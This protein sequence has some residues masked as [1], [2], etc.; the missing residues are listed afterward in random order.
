[1]RENGCRQGLTGMGYEEIKLLKQSGKSTVSLVKEEGGERYFIRKT[2]QG[3]HLVYQ[4]LRELAH[5]YL[6]AVYEVSFDKDKTTVVEE[7]IEG[8][9]VGSVKLSEKQ[10]LTIVGELCDV[11][12]FLHEKGIVHRDI[13]PSNILIAEDGHIRL[14]DFDA[15]RMPKENADQDTVPLGTK[16]YAPPEQYGFSQ[17]DERADIYA[18]GVTVKQLLGGN[19][20]KQ[21]YK[22]IFSKCTNLDPEKRYQSVRQIKK[23]FSYMWDWRA[24]I[25]CAAAAVLAAVI[26]G[27]A[28][29]D[30]V[31][32]DVSSDGETDLIVLPAPENPHW[33]GETGIGL[34][35]HVPESGVGR[36]QRYG[37]RLYRSDNKTPPDLEKDK[38]E[39]EGE[40]SGNNLTTDFFDLN[41][42]EEFWDNGFYYFSVCASGDGITYADSSYVLSDAFAFT[43][44]DAPRLPAPEGLYWT[45]KQIGE[46]RY[47]FAA[48]SN[49]EDYADQDSFNAIVYGEDREYVTNNISVKQ[50]IFEK[51]WPGVRIRPEFVNVPGKSYRFAVQVLSSRPNEYR[52]SLPVEPCP[53]EAYL[54]QPLKIPNL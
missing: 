21:R 48:I 2:L 49:W 1:M 7:Y 50:F 31:Q 10:C 17:T 47:Y 44:K 42:A 46:D 37:W 32:Q 41:F 40:M 39:R 11:L 28:L 45:M 15:A 29:S 12:I 38:W 27:K 14:I 5:S 53:G 54:S 30:S 22:R 52:S 34:W 25:L 35:G 24:G 43:G 36:D 9:T 6:P 3:Q 51:G 4:N 18:F 16:G 33:D 26:L 13:K 8:R 23:A 19:A 20:G